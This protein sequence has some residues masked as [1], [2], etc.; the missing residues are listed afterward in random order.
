MAPLHRGGRRGP[1]TGLAPTSVR[2]AIGIA[3]ATVRWRPSRTLMRYAARPA[4]R[5]HLD[6]AHPRFGSP[7]TG[8]RGP[9]PHRAAAPPRPGAGAQRRLPAEVDPSSPHNVGLE[10]PP[11]WHHPVL[12]RFPPSGSPIAEEIGV[13]RNRSVRP[14]ERGPACG[15]SGGRRAG[16]LRVAVNVSAYQLTDRSLVAAVLECLEESGLPA[17]LLELE[18]TDSAAMVDPHAAADVLGELSRRG[19]TISLDDFGTGL[20]QHRKLTTWR[21]ARSRS[22]AASSSRTRRIRPGP[23]GPDPRRGDP[24]RNLGLRC[25]RRGRSRRRNSSVRLQPRP[26]RLPG[27]LFSPPVPADEILRLLR[28]GRPL[29]A[30]T[31]IR[32]A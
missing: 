10:A 29:G 28:E 1:L 25:D 31:G 9:A 16:R 12:G 21:S 30:G 7:L 8:G 2:A 19:V 3:L 32:I 26:G 22:T 11:A 4:R 13:I 14:A 23:R 15:L 18:V 17:H 20:L 6:R 24:G 5:A 27:F